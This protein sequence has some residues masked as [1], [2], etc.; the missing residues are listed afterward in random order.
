MPDLPDTQIAI[1]SDAR[2]IGECPKRD[3]HNIGEPCS[4][5]GPDLVRLFFRPSAGSG[6][7]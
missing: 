1:L 7:C 4:V 2:Q 6:R 3:A 5:Y